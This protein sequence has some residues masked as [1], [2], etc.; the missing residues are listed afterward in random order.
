MTHSREYYAEYREREGVRER[1][2]AASKKWR[3]ANPE[4][5][6][7]SRVNWR[8]NNRDKI[9]VIDQ[10]HRDRKARGESLP[11]ACNKFVVVSGVIE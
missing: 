7:A 2:Y 8:L 10:R 9:K 6:S 11:R 1:I 4:K 5:F 3:E